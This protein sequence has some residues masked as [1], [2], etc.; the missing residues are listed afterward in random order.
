MPG[1]PAA[2]DRKL[3]RW[4]QDGDVEAY[5]ELYLR[6]AGKVY[7]YLAAHLEAPQDAEDLTGEVFIRCWRALPGYRERGIPFPAYLL[8]IAKN[9]LVDFYR[10]EKRFSHE[11]IDVAEALVGQQTPAEEVLTQMEHQ[12]LRRMLERLKPDYRTVL[13]LRFLSGL[14]PEETAHM[15][16]RSA[17]AVRV[18]QHR[19]LAALRDLLAEE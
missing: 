6:H 11:E 14:T 2:D 17:G 18:L 12:Q 10:R 3:V 9:A 13:V 5:G 8:R 19:A 4:A 7:S 15:M 16:H 1:L